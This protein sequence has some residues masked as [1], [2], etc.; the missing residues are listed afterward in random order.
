VTGRGV[1]A[2]VATGLLL[3]GCVTLLSPGPPELVARADAQLQLGNYRAA[4][5]LYDEF[6]QASPADPAALRV[7]ATQSLLEALLQSEATLQR[8]QQESALREE[9][10]SRARRELQELRAEA[11]RVKVGLER[12][13]A[14]DRRL[15][16][17]TR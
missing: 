13:K 17:R 12:L 16:R 7:R 3:S 15:E 9:E 6:L 8:L 11:M 10:L 14:L 2:I 1:T 5:A 4:R